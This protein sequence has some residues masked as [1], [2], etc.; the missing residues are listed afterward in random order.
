MTTYILNLIEYTSLI[1]LVFTL[2]SAFRMLTY[3]KKRGKEKSSL[4]SFNALFFIDYMK[5]TKK[6]TGRYGI[7]IKL[8]LISFILTIITGILFDVLDSLL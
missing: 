4:Y 8:C 5:D 7:W 6:E 1:A 3:L 2:F